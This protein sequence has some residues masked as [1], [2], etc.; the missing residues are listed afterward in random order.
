MDDEIDNDLFALIVDGSDVDSFSPM[1]D[2]DLGLDSNDLLH[3]P[4]P[5]LKLDLNPLLPSIPSFASNSTLGSD[6]IMVPSFFPHAPNVPDLSSSII[7]EAFAAF[8]AEMDSSNLMLGVALQKDQ[9]TRKRSRGGYR[10]GDQTERGR[11]NA[12]VKKGTLPRFG[13]IIEG[14]M[15]EAEERKSRDS[16]V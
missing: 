2:L 6:L 4:S 14:V 9:G 5:S 10:R 13:S 3:T 15:R 16:Q 11:G 12:E 8:A 1:D 7:N